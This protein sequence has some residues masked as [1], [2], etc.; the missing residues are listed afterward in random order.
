MAK[1]QK[2]NQASRGRGRPP[3]SGYRAELQAA[4]GKTDFRALVRHLY[5]LA[6][7]GD[8]AAAS[9]L[10]GRLV[11]SL[12]PRDEPI[13]VKLPEGDVLEQARALV[14]AV[15][16]GQITPGDGKALLDAMAAVVRIE[17]ITE[18][19]KRVEALEGKSLTN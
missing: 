12:K 7:Q 10:V 15:A 17:E 1:F 3:G 14:A 13:K 16:D 8:M 5:E 18:L 6:M 2:G 19:V 4:V 11:P 9:V